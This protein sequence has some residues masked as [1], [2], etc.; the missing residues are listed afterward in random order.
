MSEQLE[1]A[2]NVEQAPPESSA[3]AMPAATGSMP[4][5]GVERH[6]TPATATGHH[7]RSVAGTSQI[8]PVGGADIPPR[9]TVA[10]AVLLIGAAALV[11]AILLAMI[12]GRDLLPNSDTLFPGASSPNILTLEQAQ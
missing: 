10:T 11:L 3:D 2:A 1:T 5:P 4:P 6:D 8:A 9:F 7:R 12:V